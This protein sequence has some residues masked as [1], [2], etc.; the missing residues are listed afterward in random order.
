MP[1]AISETTSLASSG[2]TRAVD[3]RADAR[4]L[5]ERAIV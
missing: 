4:P 3:H 2:I 1:A 5:P